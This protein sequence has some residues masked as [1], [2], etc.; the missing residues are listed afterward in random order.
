[1]DQNTSWFT[2]LTFTDTSAAATTS[3]G[4]ASRRCAV[5]RRGYAAAPTVEIAVRVVDGHRS[6]ERNLVHSIG[7]A[8]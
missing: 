1:M 8:T 2:R 3:C 4:P 6:P 5:W 7:E